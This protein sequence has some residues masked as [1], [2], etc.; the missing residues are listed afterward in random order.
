MAKHFEESWSR[1][2]IRCFRVP[3][4]LDNMRLVFDGTSSRVNK[5]FW[6]LLFFLATDLSLYHA[7]VINTYLCDLD[8]GEF[9][10]NCPVYL[11][12]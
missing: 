4:G 6:V 11:N 10:L 2:D 9:F 3:K 7:L 1:W 12:V 8:A 5:V